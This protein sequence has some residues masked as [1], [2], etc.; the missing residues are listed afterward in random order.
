MLG[1]GPFQT[2]TATTTPTKN[3]INYKIKT[4]LKSHYKFEA[5]SQ[6]SSL[7]SKD[8]KKYLQERQNTSTRSPVL[9][10]RRKRY[11]VPYKLNKNSAKMVKVD[12]GL[13]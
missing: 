7:K 8:K 4:F 5:T 9:R 1:R 12:Y 2:F 10:G 6:P 13:M 11:Q 3:Q